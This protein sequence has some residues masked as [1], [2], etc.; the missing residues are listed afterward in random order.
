MSALGQ[1]TQLEEVAKLISCEEIEKVNAVLDEGSQGVLDELKE[2]DQ[3]EATRL[4]IRQ[5]QVCCG[6]CWRCC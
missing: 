3:Q 2:L 5:G 6:C 4:G 1:H